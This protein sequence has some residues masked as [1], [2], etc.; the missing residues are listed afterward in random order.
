M[1]RCTTNMPVTFF[2]E[3]YLGD[4]YDE[5]VMLESSQKEQ[6]LQEACS[7]IEETLADMGFLGR[8]DWEGKQ[9]FYNDEPGGE[10]ETYSQRM[11]ANHLKDSFVVKFDGRNY[12]ISNP[13]M[14]SSSQGSYNLF[15]DLLWPSFGPY[16]VPQGWKKENKGAFQRMMRV[17]PEMR[18]Y[19]TRTKKGLRKFEAEREGDT[20]V[21]KLMTF[22]NRYKSKWFY[23]MK[24][25]GGMD[26]GLHD[27]FKTYIYDAIEQGIDKSMQSIIEE[28]EYE[29]MRGQ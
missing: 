26:T 15:E 4:K 27:K 9:A 20:F 13:K 11:S 17:S 8:Y 6:I 10:A 28:E 18:A 3:S 25:R 1:G 29:L 12:L 7:F 5:F 24:Y 14:V 2:A 22:Y 21:G 19:L 23:K 16:Y